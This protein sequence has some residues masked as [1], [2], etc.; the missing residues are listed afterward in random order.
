M[1]HIREFHKGYIKLD[2]I[3]KNADGTET[4]E[5]RGWVEDEEK[6]RLTGVICSC[7]ASSVDWSRED[8]L[9]NLACETR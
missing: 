2:V 7:G 6:G 9:K 8:A 1:Q 3:R 4:E 5:K